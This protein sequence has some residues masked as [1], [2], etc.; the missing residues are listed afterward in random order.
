[1]GFIM[2][3]T[4]EYEQVAAVGSASDSQR[5]DEMDFQRT[6]G[7]AALAAGN[8]ATCSVK[9]MQKC[10]ATDTETFI[11]ALV[12]VRANRVTVSK[13]TKGSEITSR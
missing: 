9:A 12:A 7:L 3:L 8:R 6:L 13:R 11:P 2:T 10:P 1:M 4:T 5:P